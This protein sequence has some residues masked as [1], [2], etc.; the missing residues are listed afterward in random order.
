M[1]IGDRYKNNK[2]TEFVIEV[3]GDGNQQLVSNPN[4]LHRYKVGKISS[5]FDSPDT[6]NW[7]FIGNFAKATT[8]TDL[9]EKLAN[10]TLSNDKL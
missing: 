6:H 1:A 10:E 2:F 7:T 3:I 9:Y 4:D 8:F 5:W